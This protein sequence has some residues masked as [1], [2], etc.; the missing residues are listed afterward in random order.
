MDTYEDLSGTVVL[1]DAIQTDRKMI[2]ELEK[3]ASYVLTV[4]DNNR[5]LKKTIDQHINVVGKLRP[6]IVHSSSSLDK[7]HGRLETREIKAVVT[8]N[9]KIGYPGIKQVA[10]LE[11]TREII[12]SAKVT[13]ETVYPITNM[14]PEQADANDIMMF[15]REYW[16]IENKL[17]Y[18]KDMAFGED[19]STIRAENG[20]RNMSTL[21][22]FTN[23]FLMAN[24]VFNV[25]RFVD[26][27]KYKGPY[28]C[29]SLLF[30]KSATCHKMAA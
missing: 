14:G 6:E 26:N 28:D 24:S 11:R 17:H 2:E 19:R 18:R 29:H 12:K 7:G 16:A 1:A 9:T 10:R 23:S 22:N 13:K 5:A 15:K 21:R 30:N 8:E 3:K 20:P 25:K 27:L 4:E